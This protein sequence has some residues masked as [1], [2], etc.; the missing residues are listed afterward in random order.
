M[1]E[2]LDK[3][4]QESFKNLR[5]SYEIARSICDPIEFQKRHQ[6]LLYAVSEVLLCMLNE[7]E[8][9]SKL[10]ISEESSTS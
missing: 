1:S 3:E 2:I 5:I 9:D 10:Q 8:E 7:I 4:T 6:S